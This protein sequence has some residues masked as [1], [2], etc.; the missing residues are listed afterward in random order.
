VVVTVVVVIVVVVF[1]VV[2]VVIVVGDVVTGV[3]VVITVGVSNTLYTFT[4][5]STPVYVRIRYFSLNIAQALRLPITLP[6][7]NVT[8]VYYVVEDYFSS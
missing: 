4:V 8:I 3:I 6:I 5:A 1:V 2:D 7:L